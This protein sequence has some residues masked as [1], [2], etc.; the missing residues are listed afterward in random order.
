MADNYALTFGFAEGF[1]VDQAGN[2]CGYVDK[3]HFSVVSHHQRGTRDP[4]FRSSPKPKGSPSLQKQNMLS[5]DT[6]KN[7]QRPSPKFLSAQWN[8]WSA[9][10]SPH[11]TLPLRSKRH[12]VTLSSSNFTHWSSKLGLWQVTEKSSCFI[13]N[14][15]TL[16]IGFCW[17]A[18]FNKCH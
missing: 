11:P 1:W 14:K 7:P 15:N 3:C 6:Q 2:P 9:T 5:L 17:S 10:V 13:S 4:T 18:G 16:K 12:G 8:N